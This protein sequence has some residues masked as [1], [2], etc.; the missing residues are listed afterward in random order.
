MS[1][2]YDKYL[3]EH[4]ANVMKA[5][6]WLCEN[7]SPFIMKKYQF[8]IETAR[9]QIE[10]HDASKSDPNEYYAYDDYF[11]NRKSSRTHSVVEDFHMAFLIHM[12]KNPHHWQYWVL[13]PDSSGEPKQAMFMPFEYVIEMICDWFSFSLKNGLIDEIFDFYME[14][15][16][17]IFLNRV[18]QEF[19]EY[20][21]DQMEGIIHQKDEKGNFTCSL[22]YDSKVT[23][24]VEN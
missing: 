10:A 2:D 14:R 13:L 20:V 6:N 7:L 19:L 24:N 4:K 23:D 3:R 18:S 17:H 12:H 11:Y 21:L 15:K 22:W 1:L 16:H 8:M 9:P 5:Y